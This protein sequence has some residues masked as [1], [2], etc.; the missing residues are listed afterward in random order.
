M[1]PFLFAALVTQFGPM[2][3]ETPARAPQMAASGPTVADRSGPM[4]TT[5]RKDSTA[6]ARD[7]HAV[8]STRNTVV[9]ADPT[10]TVL[11]VSR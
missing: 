3:P 5:D 2:G 9:N 1:L 7:P 10:R 11:R 6:T 8:S 4:V